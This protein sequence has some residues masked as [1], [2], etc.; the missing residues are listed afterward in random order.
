MKVPPS[1]TP[2]SAP[3]LI[4]KESCSPVPTIAPRLVVS[5]NPGPAAEGESGSG[6]APVPGAEFAE[7]YTV[8]IELIDKFACYLV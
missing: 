2:G 3:W 1:Q 7:I 6:M 5:K 4:S 8:Y